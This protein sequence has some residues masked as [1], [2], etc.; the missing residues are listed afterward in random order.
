MGWSRAFTAELENRLIKPIYILSTIRV[1]SWVS[2]G[3][4]ICSVEGIAGPGYLAVDGGAPRGSFSGAEISV[5]DW[6][7]TFGGFSIDLCGFR[8]IAD[9]VARGQIC[10]L[11]VGFPG[12][13]KSSFESVALG[14]L[15][16]VTQTSPTSY[17][18]E[19]RSIQAALQSRLTDDPDKLKLFASCENL[20][21]TVG[22]N[23][24]A[25]DGTI[26]LA[27]DDLEKQENGGVGTA[28]GMIEIEGSSTFFLRYSAYNSG[29]NIATVSSSGAFG[30]TDS[31]ATAGAAVNVYA[32]I[33]DHPIDLVRKILC[34]TGT[35]SSSSAGSNGDY[36]WLPETWGFGIDDS[37]VD[38][39]DCNYFR[40]KSQPASGTD[41]WIVYSQAVD[42][43]YSW[44]EDTISPA[45]YF[46]IERQGRLTV[47]AIIDPNTPKTQVAAQ[48][49]EE[50]IVSVGEYELFDNEI[51][52]DYAKRIFREGRTGS[53]NYT[54]T[55]DVSTFPS[56]PSYSERIEGIE[57]NESEILTE[58]GDRIGPWWVRSPSSVRLICRGWRLAP[59]CPGDLVELT[60]DLIVG[61]TR[62]SFD[63]LVSQKCL[64]TGINCNWFGAETEITLKILPDFDGFF[65]S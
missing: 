50:D 9:K 30:T 18:L 10:A 47:R 57:Q 52:I 35:A 56:L 38:H 34:S 22:S 59:L 21:V 29:T 7:C 39:E 44:I 32:Y 28:I 16:G 54:V 11:K 37:L 36:D 64:I 62:S 27:G 49:G 19:F 4:E 26:T 61:R 63:G 31:N 15:W 25:G 42:N 6:R 51:E 3:W 33:D 17:T 2:P 1:K 14:Q 41:D 48:I 60:T 20:A 23:Y 13:S 43:G 65:T 46:L 8:A 58:I 40:E 5:R 12:W 53:T 45:G 24:T 55:G